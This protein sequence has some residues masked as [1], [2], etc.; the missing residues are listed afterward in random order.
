[1]EVIDFLRPQILES[2]F[3]RQRLPVAGTA[4]GANDAELREQYATLFRQCGQE[5]AKLL[6][7]P[8]QVDAFLKHVRAIQFA[9][10]SEAA[11][12]QDGPTS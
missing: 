2:M 3:W 12:E 5:L 8:R 9:P 7:D 11:T 10:Q 1:V 6:N 4:A